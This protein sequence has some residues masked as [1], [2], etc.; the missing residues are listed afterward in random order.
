[1]S[2]DKSGKPLATAR[3]S[4]SPRSARLTVRRH[5]SETFGEPYV[6]LP[7]LQAAKQFSDG[8]VVIEG[9]G[10]IF[11]VARAQGLRASEE[12]LQELARSWSAQVFYERQ[13]L[14]APIFG[15]SDGAR[16]DIEPW[17]HPSLDAAAIR[18]RLS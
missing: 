17:L 16:V 9:G 7:S 8:V 2:F 1:L 6:A 14:D 12:I 18:A 5:I 11:L 4:D 15:G 3:G 10:R 13:P